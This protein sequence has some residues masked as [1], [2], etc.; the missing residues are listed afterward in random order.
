MRYFATISYNGAA[1][2]GWQI[3]KNGTTVEET[4][5]K[6]LST[7]LGEEIDVTGAGRTDTG[8]NAI[9]Y[10]AHFDSENPSLRNNPNR[11]LYKINAILP[12]DILISEL[13]RVHEEAHARFDAVSRTYIYNVHTGKNPFLHAF[14][15]FCKFPLDMEAMNDAARYL[16]GRQDF[17]SFEKLH[18]G[19]NS[20]ICNVSEAYWERY[21]PST[22]STEGSECYRFRITANRFLRNMVRAITGSLLEVG[23]GKAAKEWIKELIEAGDRS[24]AG[25][26]VPGNALFLTEIKYPYRTRNNQVI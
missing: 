15:Y 2:C 18:S 23:R 9:G 8:V 3:Q 12:Q 13:Y 14:S 4:V 20:S 1:Y 6:A 5:E 24:A 16:I 19:S 25:Q 22:G 7:A 17:S 10:T 26:S 11:L 21:T